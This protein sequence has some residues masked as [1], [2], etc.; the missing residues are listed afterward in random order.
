MAIL[1]VFANFFIDTNE[2]YLRMQDSFNSFKDIS[3]DKWIIN[4]RGKFAKDTMSFLRDNL[5]Q[6]LIVHKRHSNEGW[7]HDT[8]QMLPDIDGDYVVFWIED[9]IN[10]AEVDLLENIVSEMKNKDLDYMLYTFWQKGRLRERYRGVSLTYSRYI[11]YFEHNVT[12]NSIIQSNIGGSYIISAASICRLSLFN[13]IVLANDPTPRRWPKETPYDFEKGPNDT[14]WLPL[15][16]AIPKQEIFASIDDDHGCVGYCLQS[17]GI[18]PVREKRKSYA[19]WT[20]LNGFFLLKRFF[21]K[22]LLRCKQTS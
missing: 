5:G 9:H 15:R 22:I 1:N 11:D 2:R 4:A 13:R 14:H 17:R 16:V 7:F 3:A 21:N 8:R 10:L 12:N 20:N 18:Y 6:K 19:N